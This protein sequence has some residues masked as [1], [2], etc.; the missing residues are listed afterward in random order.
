MPANP[1]P[2]AKASSLNSGG[3]MPTDAAARSSSR[4]AAQARPIRDE[5]KRTAAI[6]ARHAKNNASVYVASPD[7]KGPNETGGMPLTPRGPPVQ[8]GRCQI[9]NGTISPNARVT[10]ARYSP[11]VRTLGSPNSTPKPA[12]TRP[13]NGSASHGSR[14]PA[15]NASAIRLPELVSNAAV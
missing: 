1:A 8:S 10:M 5:L 11:R 6:I 3:L 15:G 14:S 4:T 7:D 12:A 2:I 9:T 13:A